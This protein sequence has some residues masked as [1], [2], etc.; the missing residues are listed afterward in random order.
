MA[1]RSAGLSFPTWPGVA[2]AAGSV[3][4][5]G[6]ACSIFHH[7][8]QEDL[9]AIAAAINVHN[10][11]LDVY[12]GRCRP[13]KSEADLDQCKAFMLALR[14]QEGSIN[15]A[16]HAVGIGSADLQMRDL[17]QRTALIKRLEQ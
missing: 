6:I 5:F 14:N 8:K 2:L 12:N 13:M 3:L 1:A 9:D 11:A 7:A 17:K 4:C 16:L 15:S 10:H